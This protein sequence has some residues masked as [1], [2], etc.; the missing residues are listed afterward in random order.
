MDSGTI[1]IVQA[2]YAAFGKGDVPGVI[3]LLTP[4]VLWESVGNP[5]DFPALGPKTGRAAVE[6]QFRM[7]GGLLSFQ[8]FEPR[9][10]FA[11]GPDTVFVLGHYDRTVI[12]TGRAANSDFVHVF[13]I[14]NGKI[15]SYREFQDTATLAAAWRGG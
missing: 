1:G 9:Q 11:S 15:A 10:F 4:D 8:S 13:V 7:L 14:H 6:A 3:A 12:K 2:A 5:A